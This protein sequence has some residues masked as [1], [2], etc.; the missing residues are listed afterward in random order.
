MKSFTA[1]VLLAL[2]L[3]AFAAEKNCKIIYEGE[4][5]LRHVDLILGTGNTPFNP[6]TGIQALQ[7][8]FGLSSKA[9]PVF[10]DLTDHFGRNIVAYHLFTSHIYYNG[11]VALSAGPHKNKREH[12]NAIHAMFKQ[13]GCK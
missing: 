3:S 12:L 13:M 9:E 1:V 8:D 5:P 10:T 7:A 11:Q 2:S 6:R 4:A